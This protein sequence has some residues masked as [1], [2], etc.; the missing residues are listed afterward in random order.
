MVTGVTS[1]GYHKITYK[2]VTSCGVCLNNAH[3]TI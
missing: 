1:I 3:H 2:A